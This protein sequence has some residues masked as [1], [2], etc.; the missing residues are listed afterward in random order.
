MDEIR[1][2]VLAKTNYYKACS[3]M[4]FGTHGPELHENEVYISIYHY[5]E[6]IGLN[7]HNYDTFKLG[8]TL[9]IMSSSGYLDCKYSCQGFTINKFRLELLQKNHH[10]FDSYRS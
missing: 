1:K 8:H 5:L 2:A 3:E 6:F 9:T 7:P 4:D 10:I